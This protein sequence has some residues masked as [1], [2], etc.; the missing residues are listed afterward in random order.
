ML[1][2]IAGS[3]RPNQYPSWSVKS[4]PGTQ[5]QRAL[6]NRLFCLARR[7]SRYRLSIKGVLKTDFFFC[8][9][10]EVLLLKLESGVSDPL[11]PECSL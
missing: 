1:N 9:I 11:L 2:L 5:Q 8:K 10:V 4:A 3:H 6:A 7:D